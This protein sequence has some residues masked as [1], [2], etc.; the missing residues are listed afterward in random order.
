MAQPYHTEKAPASRREQPAIIKPQTRTISVYHGSN[1][2]E[3]VKEVQLIRTD[4][5][6]NQQPVKIKKHLCLFGHSEEHYSVQ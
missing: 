4:A 5:S 6:P 3:K 2:P 1:Q